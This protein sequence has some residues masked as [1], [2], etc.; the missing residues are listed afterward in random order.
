MLLLSFSNARHHL[1][2]YTILST[3]LINWQMIK[4]DCWLFS[5]VLLFIILIIYAC[6]RGILIN[7]CVLVYTRMQVC[8]A[9]ICVSG[10]VDCSWGFF[11][12][13]EGHSEMQLQRGVLF[14]LLLNR[15]VR[16][17][18]V[19][20]ANGLKFTVLKICKSV[21]CQ[22]LAWWNHVRI[23]VMLKMYT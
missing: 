5:S 23:Q 22:S 21:E 12:R 20:S 13:V 3:H 16:S 17:T 8:A 7:K 10:G 9:W 14:N 6:F 1:C 2:L 11:K 18:F 19:F 15:I 4:P